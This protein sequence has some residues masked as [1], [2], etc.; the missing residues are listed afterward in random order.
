MWILCGGLKR[1]GSTLQF[2]IVS[3]I[4]ERTGKGYRTPHPMGK[5][6]SEIKQ[7]FEE[8]GKMKTFKTHDCSDAIRS[9]V[10]KNGAKVVFIYRDIRDVAVSMMN[11]FDWTFI[12]L[13]NKNFFQEYI[14]ACKNWE[15]LPGIYSSKYEDVFYN[16]KAEIEKIAQYLE[17]DLKDSIAEEIAADL[18]ISNQKKKMVL[19]KLKAFFFGRKSWDPKSQLHWNHINSGKE[20]QWKKALN[21]IEIEKLN[22]ICKEWLIEKKYSL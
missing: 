22:N 16:M 7:N 9:E 12:E 19:P 8:D 4:V 21:T 2:Q 14:D 1:S 5:D 15:A 6:F 11:K 18:S 3:E 13:T 17:I 20:G 10:E